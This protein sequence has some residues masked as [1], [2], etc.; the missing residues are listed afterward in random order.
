MNWSGALREDLARL[1]AKVAIMDAKVMANP[2]PHLER[3]SSQCIELLQVIED[4][5]RALSPDSVFDFWDKSADKDAFPLPVDINGE[6][7]IRC[8][9]A[10]AVIREYR[11]KS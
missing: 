11:T 2:K 6:A 9:A 1:K 8:N 7:L 10:L 4:I 3:M 5:E